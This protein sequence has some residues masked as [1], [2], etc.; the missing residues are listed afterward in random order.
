LPVVHNE[1]EAEPNHRGKFSG[2]SDL[3]RKEFSFE[4]KQ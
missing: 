4:K 2:F 3:G 1:P